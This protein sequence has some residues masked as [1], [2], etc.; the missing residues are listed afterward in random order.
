MEY[1]RAAIKYYAAVAETYHDT[2]YAPI[3]LYK[4]IMIEMKKGMNNEV[5]AD[6]SLFLNRYPDDSNAAELKNLEV[7]L[8]GSK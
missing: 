2:K 5:L 8:V 6:V 1:E 3:S 7:K 4:K